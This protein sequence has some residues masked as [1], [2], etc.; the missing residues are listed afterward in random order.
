MGISGGYLFSALAGFNS[1]ILFSKI[2]A[3]SR[4]FQKRLGVGFSLENVGI[5]LQPYTDIKEPIP[6]LFR[7]AIYY[8]PMY[9]HLIINGDIVRI[10]DSNSF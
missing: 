10:L 4:L 8:K 9:I 3:R 6:A 7:T 2:G 1:Q 5:L